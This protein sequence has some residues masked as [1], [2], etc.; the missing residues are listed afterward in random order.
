MGMGKIIIC[1][2]RPEKHQIFWNHINNFYW[3]FGFTI[4]FSS[5]SLLSSSQEVIYINIIFLV[6]FGILSVI[7]WYRAVKNIFTKSYSDSTFFWALKKNQTSNPFSNTVYVMM[8]C[9]R[10]FLVIT[11][12]LFPDKPLSALSIT[13]FATI[14]ILANSI[15]NQPFKI[16]KKLIPII[17]GLFALVLFLLQIYAVNLK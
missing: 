8:M 4:S 10:I 2:L 12:S 7:L 3:I 13:M 11:I 1:R 17:E 16:Y 9:R 6:F 15:W 14:F 5:L